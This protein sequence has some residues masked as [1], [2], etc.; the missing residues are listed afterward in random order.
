LPTFLIES[1]SFHSLPQGSPYNKVSSILDLPF[2]MVGAAH[3]QP[4]LHVAKSK[5]LVDRSLVIGAHND[6]T[7][8]PSGRTQQR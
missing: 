3:Q 1:E 6:N 5:A 2:G 8:E 7:I 4:C